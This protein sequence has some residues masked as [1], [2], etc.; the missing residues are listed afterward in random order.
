MRSSLR[1]LGARI[2]LM[3]NAFCLG[4][5]RSWMSSNGYRHGPGRPDGCSLHARLIRIPFS[6]MHSKS[7]LP[8]L[9]SSLHRLPLISLLETTKSIERPQTREALHVNGILPR[10]WGSC[11]AGIRLPAYASYPIDLPDHALCEWPCQRRQ[12]NTTIDR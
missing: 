6:S 8:F 2:D 5:R 3:L 11:R 9:L 4:P 1:P 7:T 10:L 12:F